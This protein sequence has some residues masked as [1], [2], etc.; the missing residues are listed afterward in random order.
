MRF[1]REWSMNCET[2]AVVQLRLQTCP[3][4]LDSGNVCI[5]CALPAAKRTVRYRSSAW[6]H[7]MF[8]Q[9]RTSMDMRLAARTALRCL[10]H[11]YLLSPSRYS[12]DV[13]RCR[14]QS[15]SC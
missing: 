12:A 4:C 9:R 8:P 5:I 7:S 13:N 2:P 15:T 1:C 11:L 14:G 3:H 6:L 10:G